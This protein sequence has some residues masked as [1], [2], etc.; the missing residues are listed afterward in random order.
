MFVWGRGCLTHWVQAL[1]FVRITHVSKLSLPRSSCV[2]VAIVVGNNPERMTR[3]GT[4]YYKAP[5]ERGLCLIN[6]E[7][8]SVQVDPGPKRRVK[9]LGKIITRKEKQTDQ[10]RQPQERYQTDACEYISME[11]KTNSFHVGKSQ[12]ENSK[13][14]KTERAD[15]GI[16]ARRRCCNFLRLDF[17]CVK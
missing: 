12:V 8:Y 5:Q 3:D 15:R 2:S 7:R 6:W 9:H 1:R 4:Q 11:R 14:Q 16:K 17:V 13:I 10:E